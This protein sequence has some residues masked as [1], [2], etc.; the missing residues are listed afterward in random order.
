LSGGNQQKLIV[1]RELSQLPENSLVLA[2]HPT[3]GVDLG[4]IEFI[5]H[6]LI[7]AAQQGAGVLLISSELEEL[8]SLSTRIGVIFREKISKWFELK[9]EQN[10]YDE[11]MIGLAMLGGKE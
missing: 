7:K 8:M 11:K 2:V 9:Q 1:A 3:R 5:H 6:Q 10:V 4:A